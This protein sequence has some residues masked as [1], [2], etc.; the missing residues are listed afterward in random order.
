V[1]A[2]VIVEGRANRLDASSADAM[3]L[4]NHFAMRPRDVV[5]VAATELTRWNRFIQQVL[6]TIQTIVA[7]TESMF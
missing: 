4:A 5:Y 2:Y 6:S 3:L 1:D 7:P